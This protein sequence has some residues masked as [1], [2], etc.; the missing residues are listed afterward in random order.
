MVSG[1]IRREKDGAKISLYL[2]P[3]DEDA[4]DVFA[5]KTK[6]AITHPAIYLNEYFK[7]F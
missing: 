2:I 3:N 1:C 5:K 6:A 7:L 4:S